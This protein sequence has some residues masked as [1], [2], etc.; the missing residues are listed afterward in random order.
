MG[1]KLACLKFPLA[2]LLK[3]VT[4]A[5]LR[6]YKGIAEQ[7]FSYL[8]RLMCGSCVPVDLAGSNVIL[9]ELSGGTRTLVMQHTALSEKKS[10]K[11]SES[12]FREH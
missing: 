11:T 8:A 10:R 12:H 4:L 5:V 7:R 2:W 3:V 9:F 1:H 6:S